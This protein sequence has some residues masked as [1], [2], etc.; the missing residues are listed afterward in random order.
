MKHSNRPL[1]RAGLAFV[2][3][4]LMVSCGGGARTRPS[5]TL[6]V[7]GSDTMVNVVQAWA[8]HYR[9]LRPDVNVEVSGGGSGVGIAALQRGTID[10]ATASRNMKPEEFEQIERSTGYE[11]I[12]FIVGYD[13]LAV[14][15]HRDNPLETITLDQLKQVFVEGGMTTRW[16]QLGVNMPGRDEIVRISRQSSSGTYEFFREIV[17]DKKDFKL[18]SRDMN[19]SK[20]VVEL[21]GTARTAIGY[22]GLG[23]ANPGVKILKVIPRGRTEGV[24]PTVP[25]TLDQSYPLARSL[26]VFTLGEPVGELK[27]FIDWILSPRGQEILEENGYVPVIAG[28]GR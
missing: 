21:V 12:D 20:E 27:V 17:L 15:V 28:N 4:S 25:T 11:P 5:A 26:H 7:K 22:S 1:A 18:G 23:Y 13:A 16:S 6:Q 14:Y 10:M 19:G 8:E 9:E 3:L 2:L 24:M